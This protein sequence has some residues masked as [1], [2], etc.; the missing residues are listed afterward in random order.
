MRY[1]IRIGASAAVMAML[2]LIPLVA[3][4]RAE[5]VQVK[6]RGSVD[7]KPFEC[8]DITRSSSFIACVSTTATGICSSI[9]LAPIIIIAK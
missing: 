2:Y 9:S 8:T 4:L 1:W 5:T 7:L 6:Y 3:L